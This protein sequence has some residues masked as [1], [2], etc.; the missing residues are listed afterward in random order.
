MSVPDLSFAPIRLSGKVT[1]VLQNQFM[2][3]TF[4]N[5]V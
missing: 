3:N 1:E 5:N 2:R 4:E